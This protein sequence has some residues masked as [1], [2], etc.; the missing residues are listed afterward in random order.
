M[1]E[2]LRWR[3]RNI[4]ATVCIACEVTAAGFLMKGALTDKADEKVRNRDFET[5]EVLALSGAVPGVAA[6]IIYD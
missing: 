6:K 5:A 3:L 2:Q 4:F 1:S